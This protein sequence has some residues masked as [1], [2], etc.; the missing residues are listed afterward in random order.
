MPKPTSRSHLE[1]TMQSWIPLVFIM[2]GLTHSS[3]VE[4]ASNPSKEEKFQRDNGLTVLLR[5][6]QGARE[7]ALVVLFSIGGDQDPPDRSG[8]AHLIEH[9]Y[10]TAAAGKEK[11]RTADE[12]IK[13]YPKG[14]NA[15]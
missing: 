10:V 13:R 7:T 3:A 4:Q 9:V 11:S 14:W 6:I 15:L 12:L 1:S 5:P 8:L 2:V